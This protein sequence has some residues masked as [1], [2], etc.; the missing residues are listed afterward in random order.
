[1]SQYNS[2]G[3]AQRGRSY[4]IT[5]VANT[6]VDKM[7]ERVQLFLHLIA[8]SFLFVYVL[9]LCVR[10]Y[11]RSCVQMF[12]S[13]VSMKG[14]V[15]IVTGGNAGIGFHTAKDLALRGGRVILACRS[16]K[17]GTTA[18]DKIIAETG[19]GDVIY[20]H[21]NLSSLTSVRKFAYEFQES[22]QRLDVLINNAGVHGLGDRYTED[23]ILEGMQINFF[24]P[25]LLTLCLIPEL[26]KTQGRVVNLSSILYCF[27]SVNLPKINEVNYYNGTFT[28]GNSKLCSL[29]F[30]K[31]LSR[32]VK[33]VTV[34]AVHP[35]VIKT[36]IVPD[37]SPWYTRY[38]FAWWC[39]ICC[40]TVEEGAQTVIYLAVSDEC[41]DI[42]G[43]FFIDCKPRL[44]M[45]KVLKVDVARSL[46]TYAE[47]L[48]GYKNETTVL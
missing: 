47:N 20:M 36:S 39:W 30:T 13:K 22:E 8:I 3:T 19:N 17:R 42:S 16:E 6:Q 48:V 45:N 9:M 43:E 18:R 24:A 4:K 23:N 25:F 15:I 28:Y 29:L 5:L 14:K 26:I 7:L 44:L 41:R 10:L 37:K 32:R 11:M 2:K 40:R 46:W 21:L 12:E 31:E 27:G 33:D 1:M 34:N 38:F 35:G